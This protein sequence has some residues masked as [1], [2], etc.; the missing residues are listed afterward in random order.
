MN[1][2]NLKLDT[3]YTFQPV[4]SGILKGL[5]YIDV[6]VSNCDHCKRVGVTNNVFQSSVM[7]INSNQ[8]QGSTITTDMPVSILVLMHVFEDNQACAT[9][10][11]QSAEMLPPSDTHVATAKA[12]WLY[13]GKGENSYELIVRSKTYI[14]QL[15]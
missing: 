1:S 2:L 8:P 13:N 15:K 9:S 4:V 10:A 6:N 12:M 5:K 7:F 11:T 3:E 14:A